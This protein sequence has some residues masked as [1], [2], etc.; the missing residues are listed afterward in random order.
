MKKTLRGLA[1][2]VMTTT[3]A[4]ILVNC[5]LM[6]YFVFEGNYDGHPVIVERSPERDMIFIEENP[7]ERPQVKK[8]NKWH[9][10]AADRNR[11]DRYDV[12]ILSF[13]KGHELERF[14]HPDSLRNIKK[15]IYS[16]GKEVH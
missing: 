9:L 13:P 5:S 10:Y 2:L 8:K 4:G 3:I 16:K 6:R 12:I 11:D 14:I 1:K 15:Y 7:N